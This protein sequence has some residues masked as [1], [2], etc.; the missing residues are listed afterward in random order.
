MYIQVQA[1]VA[2]TT[3]THMWRA[4]AEYTHLLQHDYLTH[5][6]HS[7]TVRQSAIGKKL[8]HRLHAKGKR[9]TEQEVHETYAF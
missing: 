8:G 3:H 6:H 4:H 2:C 5:P 1:R 7:H 9:C